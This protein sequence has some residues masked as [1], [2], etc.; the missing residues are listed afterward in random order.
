MPSLALRAAEVA[1]GE[2]RAWGLDPTAE[3]SQSRPV[4]LARVA[5]YLAGA[6]REGA[7][8]LGRG[9]ADLARQGRAVAW[10]AAAIGW[11][12]RLAALP[13]ELPPPWRAGARELE[14]D[15]RLGLRGPWLP[16]SDVRAGRG[17]PEPGALA[18][19]W[20]STPEGWEGHVERVIAVDPAGSRFRALGGNEGGSR[21]VVEWAAYSS[22]KL[23]GFAM[24]DAARVA[25]E[26]AT[27]ERATLPDEL[28]GPPP[29][30]LVDIAWEELQ[31]ERDRLVRKP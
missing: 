17:A 1:M 29:I 18:I 11:S 22:A 31:A 15:A 23:L 30:W 10:C 26:G 25:D 13:D 6:E 27:D 16:A 9:L 2:A 14:R 5:D 21:W 7:R 19:Y 8:E 24:P 28:A 4:P 12:E 3:R 20:R